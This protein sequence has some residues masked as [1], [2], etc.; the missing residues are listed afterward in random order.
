MVSQI[1]PT[2]LQLNGI[3][4]F[5]AAE[6][7]FL[8]LDLT[9]TKAYFYLKFTIIETSFILKGYFSIS[10]WRYS[11]FSFLYTLHIFHSLFDLQRYIEMLVSSTIETKL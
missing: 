7:F 3:N 9:I 10:W 6:T 8:D 1:Y 2:L 11:S 4:S 5:D